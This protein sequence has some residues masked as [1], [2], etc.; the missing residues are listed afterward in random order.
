MEKTDRRRK[1]PNGVIL[2]FLPWLLFSGCTTVAYQPTPQAAQ[3][4]PSALSPIAA[5]KK[6]RDAL[7]SA[8]SSVSS[9]CQYAYKDI[10]VNLTQFSY[11]KYEICQNTRYQT[12]PSSATFQYRNLQDLTIAHWSGFQSGYHT[13]ITPWIHWT[14]YMVDSARGFADGVNALRY[15]ATG[16]DLADDGPKFARFQEEAKAWRALPIKPAQPESVRRL[17][18]LAED[19]I[20][21]RNFEGAVDY[22]EQGLQI[23]P[24]WPE[25]H[26]NT[27]LVYGE[28]GLYGQAAIR[29]KRYLA[30]L[31]DAPD[32]KAAGDQIVIWESKA[33]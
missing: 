1:V 25:G 13:N 27:A 32:A 10:H 2:L 31:P 22:Y 21:N 19:A 3:R 12:E 7:N 20:K 4:D 29:M 8:G 33:R 28:L 24:M 14:N 26:F 11:T 6:V 18:L 5:M 16:R 15:Y 17:R 9:G 30:L 23:S